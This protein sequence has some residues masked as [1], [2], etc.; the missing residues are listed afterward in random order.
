ME[1]QN[2]KL[3]LIRFNKY[4][5][6][7]LFIFLLFNANQPNCKKFVEIHPPTNLLV[8][9][10]TFDNDVSA[11]AALLAIYTQ[12]QG[13]ESYFM[14][15]NIGLLSDEL[16]N[17][18]LATQLIQFY[19]NS[20]NAGTNSGPWQNAY[21]YIYQANAVVNGLNTYPGTSQSVRQQLLGEAKFI[22]AFWLF[23]LT[24]LYGDIPLV[25]S[26]DYS[27]N[28]KISRSSTNNIYRQIIDDLKD[29]KSLLNKNYIDAS[30]T[31]VTLERVRPTYWAATALLARTYLY[32]NKWDSAEAEATS[33]INNS[34]LYNLSSDL[35]SVF[36]ANSSEAIWQIQTPLPSSNLATGDG[37]N[38]ILVS[39]PGNSITNCTTIS[40]FLMNDF[41][42]GDNRKTNWIGSF[43]SDSILYYYF[44]YKYKVYNQSSGPATEYTMVLRLAEQYLIRAEARAQENKLMDAAI[45]LNVIRNRAGLPNTIA[46]TQS[47]FLTA[48]L[49]ERKV[50]LFTE[51]GHRWFDMIRTRNANSVMGSPLNVCQSKGG[52]WSSNW[53][54]FP[55]PQSERSIDQ[56]LSQNV[57]Y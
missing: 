15:S 48:I 1:Y 52:I 54:L 42:A 24:N 9:A 7:W 12:M 20:L 41:E 55:I 18:S 57:G 49:H 37:Q 23:Y 5:Y 30:D 26:V 13:L 2:K 32:T 28:S 44:P 53:Q 43:T 19:T 29:A 45:D 40:P 46:V 27:I 14:S 17:Y 33:V 25:T 21:N 31:V 34:A 22:R 3:S 50:E 51:W 56:N 35:N 6:L 4:D 10:N 16:T 47:D 38:Y 36:L 8:T 11:T 39:S